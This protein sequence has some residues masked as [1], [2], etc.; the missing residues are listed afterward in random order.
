VHYHGATLLQFDTEGQNRVLRGYY[1][2]RE[3]TVKS[4]E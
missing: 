3:L 2:T 1:D 4:T